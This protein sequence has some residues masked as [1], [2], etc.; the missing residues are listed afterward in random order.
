[1]ENFSLKMAG[2]RKQQQQKKTNRKPTVRNAITAAILRFL[3][4]W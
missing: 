2:E 3:Y 4:L 1:M